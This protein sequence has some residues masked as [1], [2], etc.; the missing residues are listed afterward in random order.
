V[1]L[2]LGKERGE[3]LGALALCYL[4]GGPLYHLLP[5][6]GPGYFDPGP[7]EFL[8][9][10]RDLMV[11]GVRAW[12]FDNT[13]SIMAGRATVL[14]TWGYIACLPSLHVAQEFVMLYYARHSRLALAL[15]AVFTAITLLSVVVLGWHYPVDSLGGALVALAAIA[16]ARWQRDALMPRW[17]DVARD[18]P[19]LPRKPLWRPFLLAYR[20]EREGRGEGRA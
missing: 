5:G 9:G 6:A 7:F 14:K 16:L 13:G 8:G 10:H 2:R 11:N 3:Y 12:L 15:S 4:I 1:G 20:L 19:L 18:Q 17:L